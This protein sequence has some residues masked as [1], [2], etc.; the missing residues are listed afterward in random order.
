MLHKVV[1]KLHIYG[2]IQWVLLLKG[3]ILPEEQKTP[4][5]SDFL[6]SILYALNVENNI[7]RITLR[8]Q[9]TKER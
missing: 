8:W 7:R 4:A 5:V 2:N 3:H 9:N 1:Q 6:C